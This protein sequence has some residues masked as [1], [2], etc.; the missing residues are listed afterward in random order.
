MRQVI[1]SIRTRSG[2]FSLLELT[3]TISVV[4][5]LTGLAV[6]AVSGMWLDAQ[7][8]TAVNSFIHSVFLARS[9]ATQRGHE[10]SICRSTDGQTCSNGMAD[11]QVGWIVFVNNDRDQPPV[12]DENEALL[13]V[14]AARDIGTITSN[15]VSY[16]FRPHRNGV[17]NGT[18]VFCDQRGPSHARAVIINYAGRPR[19]A[20]RDSD[21]RPL[22][23]PT[24]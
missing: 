11:W 23:C 9:T 8:V 18:V 20:T 1:A 13:S 15:R 24:G 2:G 6:P 16:S 12:R 10:V 19:V 21:R 3:V 14:F 4:A 17:V 22:R 7:R 5:V